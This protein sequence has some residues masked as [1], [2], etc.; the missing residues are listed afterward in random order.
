MD[1]Q[2]GGYQLLDS[3]KWRVFS[4]D[5]LRNNDDNAEGLSDGVTNKCLGRKPQNE[6]KILQN[7]NPF[8]CTNLKHKEVAQKS[9]KPESHERSKTLVKILFKTK[10]Q[11]RTYW[12]G[13]GR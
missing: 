2:A 13:K 4:Q 1:C 5:M 3:D 10:H 9:S 8:N 12:S 7:N 6:R 11:P